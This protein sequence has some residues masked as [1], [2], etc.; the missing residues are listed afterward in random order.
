MSSPTKWVV[1]TH[2]PGKLSEIQEFLAPHGVEIVSVTEFGL[3]IPEETEDSFSGNALIKARAAARGS[4]LPALADD[5]GLCVSAL[6][7]KPGVRTAEWGGP[8]RDSRLS[9][10]RIQAEMGTSPDRSAC[11][12]A[13][14]ALVHPD[15]REEV[16]EGRCEG[17]LVWPPRG[18]N[19]FGHDPMFVPEAESRTFAEMTRAEKKAY[20]HRAR[21]FKKLEKEV[22]GT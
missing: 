9:M 20:S 12:V 3:P 10:E 22:F 19:G 1:A 14:L 5:S 2:N 6:G 11:F 16:F 15:G 7:G 17:H 4:D 21:A 18:E 13:V 8:E